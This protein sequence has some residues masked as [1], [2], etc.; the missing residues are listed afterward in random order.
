MNFH[1]KPGIYRHYKG[2]LYQFIALGHDANHD[3]RTVVV[4]MPLQLDGAHLGP[5]MAVRTIEDFTAQ[6]HVSQAGDNWPVCPGVRECKIARLGARSEVIGGRELDL[7]H[8]DQT[9]K[10]RFEYLG[11]VLTS[12]MLPGVTVTL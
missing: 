10:P 2:P 5:R 8:Y 7:A 6:M 1:L 3:D 4:Y 9:H 12:E 11:P